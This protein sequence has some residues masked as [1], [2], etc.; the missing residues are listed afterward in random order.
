MTLPYFTTLYP[1]FTMTSTPILQKL[2]S[3]LTHLQKFKFYRTTDIFTD[4]AKK[5]S[6]STHIFFAGPPK[7]EYSA[8]H[9]GDTVS[10]FIYES[11]KG[12]GGEVFAVNSTV[13]KIYFY[14]ADFRGHLA[15][16]GAVTTPKLWYFKSQ[17]TI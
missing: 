4:L 3:S 2:Y 17:T 11:P 14:N 1:T 16:F 8:L 10:I 7:Y 15:Y 13:L 5:S 12:R 6:S 9:S